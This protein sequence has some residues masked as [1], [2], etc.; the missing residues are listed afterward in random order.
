MPVTTPQRQ[1]TKP[2]AR[3]TKAVGQLASFV[4]HF[5]KDA[6]ADPAA[7]AERGAQVV[8]AST[9]AKAA[10]AAAETAKGATKTAAKVATKRAV[11]QVATK[12]PYVMVVIVVAVFMLAI[13]LGPIIW[14]GTGNANPNPLAVQLTFA[15]LAGGG[16]ADIPPIVFSAYVN[17]AAQA[18]T[19]DP[20]CALRPAILAGIGW[21]ETTHG[22]FGGAMADATGDVAPPIIGIPLNG[23][24]NTAVIYDTDGGLWDQDTI[25][26][27]AV[28]PMQF[29]PSSWVLYG[30]DGNGDGVE[31]PHNVFDAALGAVAHLCAASPTDMNA[32]ED[33]LRAAIFAYNHSTEYVDAVM[34]RILYYDYAL[35]AGFSSDPTALLAN[36]NF[37]ACAAAV[38]DLETGQ[39][40]ARAISVLSSIV[41]THSIHV[42]PLKSGH[43]QCVGGGSLASNPYCTE[44]HHWYGRGVDI[45]SVDGVAVTSSNASAHAIV[46]WLTT[47]P[48]GDPIRPNVG[49]PWPEFNALPG[50]FH[51]SDHTDHIHLGFCGSRWSGGV[52]SDSC[53]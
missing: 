2:T 28:G 46:Q 21:R 40:D 35:A 7:G 3:S 13:V 45:G 23:E 51:D 44:S 25:W 6:P 16:T 34:A 12:N 30:Q 53:A 43:Y 26:D 33:A 39:V 38:A 4:S 32:S 27:R 52:W 8:P 14:L 31:N 9:R 5:R 19:F 50:F 42:C 49:S 17:A 20:N 24:N 41:Q 48:S 11:V 37:S 29:I 36:P 15:Q 47:L 22:T 10:R 18:A 1:P